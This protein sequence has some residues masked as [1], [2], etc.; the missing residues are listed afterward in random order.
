MWSLPTEGRSMMCIGERRRRANGGGDEE[1]SLQLAAMWG[2][3]RRQE[4]GEGESA[5]RT[6]NV[7]WDA[8]D[9]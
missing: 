1:L 2:A 4:R 6:R 7:E 8:G 5:W 9:L 3:V